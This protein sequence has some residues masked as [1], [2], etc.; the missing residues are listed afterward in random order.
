MGINNIKELLE[1]DNISTN[2]ITKFGTI[3]IDGN[4][5]MM[6]IIKESIKNY[7]NI[8]K[9]LNNINERV[10]Y[11]ISNINERTIQLLTNLYERY[12]YRYTDMY[13]VMNSEIKEN[14]NIFRIMSIIMP[15]IYMNMNIKFGKSFIIIESIN[16]PYFVIKN[17]CYQEFSETGLEILVVTNDSDAYILLSDMEYV[18]VIRYPSDN[19]YSFKRAIH[20]DFNIKKFINIVNKT[21]R[22]NISV[23]NYKNWRLYS[24]YEIKEVYF[25]YNCH[26]K[27]KEFI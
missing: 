19:K 16:K 6:D 10:D 20:N 21:R 15:F 1:N 4:N 23:Y 12:A 22:N 26:E 24:N 14:C 5:F 17:L 3:V 11:L 9:L 7:I 2:V 13:F 8:R 27:M 18:S 25:T